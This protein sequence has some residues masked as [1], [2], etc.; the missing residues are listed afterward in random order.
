MKTDGK[1]NIL[2]LTT[3]L[4]IGGI[5]TYILM[6][7]KAM[8][9]KGHRV[10]VLSSGGEFEKDLGEYKIQSHCF[11]IRTKSEIHP[12]LWWALPGI[13]KLV[14]KE[15]FDVIHAHTRVTQVLAQVVSKISRV[16]YVSTSHGFFTPNWG[17]K[18]FPCWGDRV[19]AISPLVAEALEKTHHVEKSRIAVVMNAVDRE[20]LEHRL[21]EKNKAFIRERYGIPKDAVVVGSISRLVEDKGHKH[22]IRAFQKICKDLPNLFLLIAGDG[23]EKKNLEERI[24]RYGLSLRV[25]IVP[26]SRDVAGLLS[27]LDVFVHPA[28]T[29]EGFGLSIAEAMIAKIPVIVTDIPAVN[30]IIRDRVNGLVV[31]P[32]DP[33]ALAQAISYLIQNH[34]ESR[35]IAVRGYETATELCRLER[36]VEETEQVYQKAIEGWEKL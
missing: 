34:G 16:P 18:L 32:E 29:R 1:L 2:H 33:E 13:L 31:P 26:A 23:R 6:L 30:T 20:G 36:Q 4:N 15:K 8:A 17:R 19:I 5:S 28:T 24:W 14:R 12:K 7:G 35:S 27:I 10:S 9:K 3:H 22:L 25:K 11:P 21:S